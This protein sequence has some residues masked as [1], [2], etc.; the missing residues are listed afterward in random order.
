MAGEPPAS[1]GFVGWRPHGGCPALGV[2]SGCSLAIYPQFG[3]TLESPEEP[4]HVIGH[5]KLTG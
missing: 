3:G 2:P 4:D 1:P 5:Q